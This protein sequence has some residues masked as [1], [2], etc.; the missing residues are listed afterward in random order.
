M[1]N[2]LSLGTEVSKVNQVSCVWCNWKAQRALFQSTYGIVAVIQ[3]PSSRYM[4]RSGRQSG[5]MTEYLFE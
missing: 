3:P 2:L 4:L 1:N 5:N